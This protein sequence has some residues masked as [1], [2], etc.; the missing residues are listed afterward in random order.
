VDGGR[1]RALDRARPLS[2]R[3]QPRPELLAT[4]DDVLASMED[5]ATCIVNALDEAMYRAGRIPGSS[6]LPVSALVDPST[7]TVRPLD[8]LRRT[9]ADVVPQDGPAPIAYCGGGI[10]ATLDVFALAL[11]GRTDA[12]LYD[13]SMTDWTS[14]PALPVETG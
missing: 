7:G 10:A 8:Q 11:A 14:D 12:R 13:G 4:R 5:G 2:A 1:R 3:P 6:H 9:I